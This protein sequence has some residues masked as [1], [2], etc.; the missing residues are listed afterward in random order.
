MCRPT[1]KIK[2]TGFPDYHNPREQPYYQ[3]LSSRYTVVECNEPDYV[4]DGGQSFEHVKYDA[5]KI[6]IC[7]ENEIPDFNA[8]DYAISSTV[9]DI[10]DRH[11]RMPWCAFSPHYRFLEERPKLSP[12]KLLSRKFCSFVVSNAEF[13]DPLRMK[14]FR[15]LSK[16]KKVDSGGRFLNN[17]GG[18]VNDKDAFCRGYKF[19][20]AFENSS[21]LGYVTEKIVDSYHASS[22]PIYY[23]DP[24]IETDFRKES[25]VYVRGEGDIERSVEEIIRLDGDDDA[26]LEMVNAPC[27]PEGRTTMDYHNDLQQFL[28]HIFDQPLT[29]ARRLCPY[30]HQ[31]MMR[32]HLGY[33]HGID[34]KIGKSWVYRA[35]IGVCGRIR[36]MRL[37]AKPSK[38]HDVG[39]C[40][41]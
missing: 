30:G 38:C 28:S 31:A 20:I 11:M 41:K 36:A 26:Y 22:I 39:G 1:I 4:I 12:E 19:N 5:V 2:F 14:F 13:G 17:I 7:S 10:G 3:F 23:G 34:Y 37:A 27:L 24:T 8:Y 32:R 16:Y 25:M 15:E 21:S 35:A 18:P 9:L 40:S 33:L 29:A 6:L